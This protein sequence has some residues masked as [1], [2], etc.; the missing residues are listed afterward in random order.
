MIE[1]H[2]SRLK[3]LTN[4]G[5]ENCFEIT[6]KSGE[7]RSKQYIFGTET[8][9]LC[10]RW[11]EVLS[12]IVNAAPPIAATPSVVTPPYVAPTPTATKSSSQQRR[13]DSAESSIDGEIINALHL[14][15]S[16]NPLLLQAQN[17]IVDTNVTGAVT[18]GKA[19]SGYLLKE[20][21]VEGKGFQK[22]YFVLRAP[23]VLTYFMK[24][25]YIHMCE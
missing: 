22:R 10:T 7:G 17:S 1:L 8:D 2:G 15:T 4:P 19:M 21:P 16:T 13:N 12:P 20:S 5:F 9:A 24:V 18:G 3:R 23:G 14:S 25:I 11:M 6:I